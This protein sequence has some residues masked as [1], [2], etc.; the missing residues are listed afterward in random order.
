MLNPYKH[1]TMRA[2]SLSQFHKATLCYI[3]RRVTRGGD[4]E[5]WVPRRKRCWGGLSKDLRLPSQCLGWLLHYACLTLFR[6]SGMH[7]STT[8]LE[9]DF[10]IT[11][12]SS[13]SS[14]ARHSITFAPELNMVTWKYNVHN[15]LAEQI[16]RIYYNQTCFG[17]SA[18][19]GPV[20]SYGREYLHCFIILRCNLMQDNHEWMEERSRELREQIKSM[21]QDYSDLLQTMQLIDAIQLLG[22]AYHFEKEISDAL[23]KVYDAD[24]NTHGLYEASLRF[25]LLRQ[26]GYNISPGSLLQSLRV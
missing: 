24:F 10:Y 16:L 11:Q 23:S 8:K 26:H 19:S 14:K 9:C 22:V 2:S 21:L 15:L 17:L 3:Y 7:L 25:R 12:V 18:R 5:L 6:C 20:A 1:R 13:S 4:H